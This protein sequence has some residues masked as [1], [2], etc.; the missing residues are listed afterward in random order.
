MKPFLLWRV[1]VRGQR[2]LLSLRQRCR[3]MAALLGFTAVEQATLSAAVF[4][5]AAEVRVPR[6]RVRLV[7][8]VQGPCLEIQLSAPDKPFRGEKNQVGPWRL[9]K[10]LPPQN[11]ALEDV[12]WVMRQIGQQAEDGLFAEIVRQNRELLAV[13]Q[14][15]QGCERQLALGTAAGRAVTAA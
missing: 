13:V 10:K 5:L 3:Q 11:L 9:T 1:T 15:L 8:Q 4:A 7:F 6:Q 12:A 2:E 14:Q